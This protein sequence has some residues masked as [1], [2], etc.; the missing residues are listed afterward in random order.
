ML[1]SINA[2]MFWRERRPVAGLRRFLSVVVLAETGD[3]ALLCDDAQI[4][5]TTFAQIK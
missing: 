4:N 3:L 1:S 2:V 5:W